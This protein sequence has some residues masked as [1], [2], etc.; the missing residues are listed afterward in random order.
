ML[1]F[2]ILVHRLVKPSWE[3]RKE[4]VDLS[5]GSM[6]QAQSRISEDMEN[7]ASNIEHGEGAGSLKITSGKKNTII[8]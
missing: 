1:F 2:L 7:M 4:M 6:E 8:I 5:Q 3:S